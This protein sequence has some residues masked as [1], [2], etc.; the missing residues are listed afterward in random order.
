MMAKPDEPN[1]AALRAVKAGTATPE[2][3]KAVAAQQKTID[4]A[5]ADKGY[6]R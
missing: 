5:G 3:Q 1:K 6:A 4:Q 2:Q